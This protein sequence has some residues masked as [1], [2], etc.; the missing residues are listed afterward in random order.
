MH[1]MGFQLPAAKSPP[2]RVAQ[3]PR[4]HVGTTELMH[5][6]AKFDKQMPACYFGVVIS[7]GIRRPAGSGS[8]T[9]LTSRVSSRPGSDRL[10]NPLGSMHKA[11]K[12]ID[13]AQ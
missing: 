9:S 12:A 5:T 2:P 3:F 10:D 13:T 11:F 1:H 4:C 6:L 8:C 7:D